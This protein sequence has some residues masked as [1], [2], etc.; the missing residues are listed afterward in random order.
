MQRWLY[1]FFDCFCDCGVVPWEAGL[2][3]VKKRL[4]PKSSL[5][6]WGG[7]FGVLNRFVT[8]RIR[9]GKATAMHCIMPRSPFVDT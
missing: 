6:N 1:R 7:R 8:I 3:I 9:V 4:F 2:S 5:K